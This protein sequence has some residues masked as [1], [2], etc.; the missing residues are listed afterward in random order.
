MEHQ[1]GPVVSTKSAEPSLKE[2]TV[3]HLP[4][5]IRHR[6]CVCWK[7]VHFDGPSPTPTRDVVAGIDGETV[8]PRVEAVG[9][10]E[11]G[12]VPP[13]P[14]VRLLDGVARQLMVAQDQARDG[15]EVGDGRA[16][17]RGEGVVIASPRTNHELCLV[18]GLPT[19]ADRHTPLDGN[20]VAY[21][22]TIPSV[23]RSPGRP[24]R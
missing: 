4:T 5:V 12:K 18:H 10:A 2:V 16:D 17:E 21:G 6:R 9:V 15:L 3:R 23:R 13:G 24:R 7:D 8:K 14:D 1:D 20:G 22:E 11:S 19:G